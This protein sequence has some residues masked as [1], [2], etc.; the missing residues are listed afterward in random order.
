L[1]ESGCLTF[2]FCVLIYAS[3]V[4]LGQGFN[5][6]CPS[7]W[8]FEGFFL[9]ELQQCS[10]ERGMLPLARFFGDYSLFCPLSE[11]AGVPVL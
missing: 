11:G 3:G 5:P 8:S 7:S 4:I 6:S 2:L 9:L 10:L 1:T